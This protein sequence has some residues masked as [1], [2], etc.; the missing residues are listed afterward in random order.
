MG[1]KVNPNGLRLGINKNWDARWYAQNREVPTLLDEDLKVRKY[2]DK[3]FNNASIARTVIER[4]K[5]KVYVT[6][7]TAKPGMVIGREGAIKKEAALVLPKCRK[8]LG[9]F[10]KS[11]VHSLFHQ[12]RIKA[13]IFADSGIDPM[14]D[15]VAA[16]I[17]VVPQD[18]SA[19]TFDKFK[20]HPQFIFGRPAR[21]TEAP[22]HRRKKICNTV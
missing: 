17:V 5:N 22:E 2:I 21:S 11:T 18:L 19:G 20:F 7:F 8:F 6:L 13:G 12:L 4:N 14:S 16:A 1:Q 15:I 10:P 9:K 3:K